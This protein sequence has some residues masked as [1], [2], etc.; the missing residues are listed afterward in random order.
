M[1][2]V[3]SKLLITGAA[4]FIGSCMCSYLN[5]LGYYQLYLM[6]DFSHDEKIK[7]YQALRFIQL[8]ERKNIDTFLQHTTIDY[9]IHLG[10]RTDTTEMN[11]EI[12]DVLNVQFSKKIWNYC[13]QHTIP[14]IYASSTATYGNGE[15]GYN[16]THA[17][18]P[19]LQ[20]LNPYGIS[21]NEFDKWAIQQQQTPPN[22]YGLKFF[23]VYGPNEY[24]K[25]RMASIVY[26]AY[27]QVVKNKSITLFKSHHA[28]YKDGEQLRDFI[29]MQDILSIMYWL[30]Q[31]N[32]TC[33]IYNAGTGKA[34][35]YIQLA[36]A[37][38]NTLQLEINIQYIDTPID[39]RDKYQYYTQANMQK[40]IEQG[41]DKKFTSIEDGVH[42]YVQKYLNTKDTV[43]F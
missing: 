43:Y 36:N 27:Q 18:I 37:L 15:H 25:K 8:V 29:Y 39:I 30:M 10:A 31:N 35:S 32:A 40:L 41:Y 33:G 1:L 42:D 12:H 28:A 5:Q 7:N 14:L 9:V 21:K 16:D 24:H 17:I 6:D 13:T 38:F 23:N 34:A 19:S 20:P 26:H 4:G 2:N 11:Y 3:N 22:W